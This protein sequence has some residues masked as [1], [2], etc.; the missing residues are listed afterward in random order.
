M[1]VPGPADW[2]AGG[3]LVPGPAGWL[4]GGMLVPGP[5]GWLAGG[6]EEVCFRFAQHV[7]QRHTI[8]LFPRASSSRVRRQPYCALMSV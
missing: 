3:M 5:A 6:M 1:L 2:L 8:N 7:G 4:A